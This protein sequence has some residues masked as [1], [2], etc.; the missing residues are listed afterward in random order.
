M[1]LRH[2]ELTPEARGRFP[3]PYFSLRRTRFALFAHTCASTLRLHLLHFCLVALVSC[4]VQTCIEV[5]SC[6]WTCNLRCPWMCACQG[7]LRARPPPIFAYGVVK[8]CA[9]ICV[10]CVYV[11]ACACMCVYVRVCASV[12]EC[13]CASSVLVRRSSARPRACVRAC[14]ALLH[15]PYSA[16]AS[17]A[18][19]ETEGLARLSEALQCRVWPEAPTTH[20]AEAASAQTQSRETAALDAGDATAEGADTA[21][22]ATAAAAVAATGAGTTAGTATAAAQG[23][24]LSQAADA[25]EDADAQQVPCSNATVPNYML[26]VYKQNDT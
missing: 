8:R 26:L 19:E 11:R 4:C 7:L 6:A 25:A 1:L 12:A 14:I 20:A 24:A 18:A 9:C 2:L 3:L 22:T 21:T 15:A 16:A 5:K 13:G 17:C 10:I 23:Q